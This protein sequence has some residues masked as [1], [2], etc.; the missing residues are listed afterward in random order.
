MLK[1]YAIMHATNNFITFMLM[2][3]I[4]SLK[5]MSRLPDVYMRVPTD[6]YDISS[7]NTGIYTQVFVSY[8]LALTPGQIFSLHLATVVIAK[9]EKWPG[10]RLLTLVATRTVRLKSE[11]TC[12]AQ[13]D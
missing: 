2:I 6:V 9:S 1:N 12:H 4:M 8:S 11:R 3:I 7:I 5:L 10:S 13:Y